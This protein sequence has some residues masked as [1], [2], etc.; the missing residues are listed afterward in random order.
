MKTIK[1]ENLNEQNNISAGENLHLNATRLKEIC[2]AYHSHSLS[3]SNVVSTNGCFT[4]SAIATRG[5]GEQI[6]ISSSSTLMAVCSST[7]SFLASF[8]WPECLRCL[9]AN[10]S[11]VKIFLQPEY[12][13]RYRS[14]PEL[15][16]L[17]WAEQIVGQ[18]D[19]IVSFWFQVRKSH[20]FHDAC[21]YSFVF[22]RLF[23]DACKLQARLLAPF[24]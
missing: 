8:L 12:T 18:L 3:S 23:A 11:I 17:F 1:Y 22:K 4:N 15:V 14:P 6:S 19:V 20:C 21:V 16:I 13:H 24:N 5:A 2:T 7:G 9:S 10:A